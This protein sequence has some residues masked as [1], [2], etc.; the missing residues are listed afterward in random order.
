MQ[1]ILFPHETIRP[2]QKDLV[3]DVMKAIENKSNL[4]A[5]APTGL[6]KTAATLSPAI[7]YALK[8]D[9]NIFFLTSRHTQH[10]IV[11][12]TI[13][14]IKEQHKTEVP[15]VSIVG[16]KWMCLQPGVESLSSNE[17]SEFCKS[18]REDGKCTYYINTKTKE[19]EKTVK[20]Q[21]VTDELLKISPL[22]SEEV[23]EHA[24]EKELCPYELAS[25]I[26][27][28]AK[29]I[30]TDY[31]YVFHPKI[32]E[33]FFQRAKIDLSK[34]I[35]IID[36]GHNLPSRIRDLS[37]AQLSDST[38]K[39]AL[40]EAEKYSLDDITLNEL[41]VLLEDLASN[42]REND[43]KLISREEFIKK[44]EAIKDY[45]NLIKELDDS[46]EKVLEQQ[47][48]SAISSIVT[49]LEEWLGPNEGFA[50][51]LTKQNTPRGPVINLSYRCLDPSLITTDIIKQAHS[52]IVM[53]G[54]MTPTSMYK[55]LLG[56]PSDTEEKEYSSPFPSENRLALI[57]PKTTTKFSKRSPQQFENIAK[58]TAGIADIVPGNVAIFFPSYAL[59]NEVN[60]YFS[61]LTKKSVFM[62]DR[63]LSKDQKQE[64][65]TAFKGYQKIGAVLLGV[66]S[67]SFG[68]G[69]DLP[70]DL[71]KAVII[72]G[73][74]LGRP[75][76]ETKELI[77]YYDKK[78]AKGWDY[79]Y[80][81]PAM[82]KTLQNA[83]RCIRSETD[84]G[85]VVFL[86]E[87][88]SW[89]MYIRCFSNEW[90]LKIKLNY[91]DTIN[92]FFNS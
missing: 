57:I 35:I 2:S 20:S 6:G 63:G 38:I 11:M 52:V 22:L 17:F 61:T 47:K 84:R 12:Q 83:G 34:S 1:D 89:P 60:S 9:L 73:L 72:V 65:L 69:I 53:S 26:A 10:Q 67:G 92:A 24:S 7:T 42:L 56:F 40:K 79:G 44:I 33:S 78:F 29:V 28:K 4:I 59:M 70:G 15:S 66:A 45:E 55:E 31:Y 82:T 77:A 8:N 48:R 90:K 87:R 3:A 16:K 71:L 54:T 88:Y 91:L 58:I 41:L 64:M 27:A 36:E 13:R 76:L 74:P 19:G 85:V 62:E 81:L 37:S 21:Q 46:S 80:V 86:D 30:V 5:H 23:K 18:L 51:I 43:E 39:F 68:E 49:F 25:F 75:D 32:S 50:R 14:M